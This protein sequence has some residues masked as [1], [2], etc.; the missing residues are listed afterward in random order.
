MQRRPRAPSALEL[1]LWHHAT[2][3]VRRL[4]AEEG[5][6]EEKA[7]PVAAAA[8][9][10]ATSK[11]PAS[12][13]K[14]LR[15]TKPAPRPPP[16]PGPA[17]GNVDRRTWQRLQR[18]HYPISARI[19]LHGMTQEAAHAALVGFLLR[20]QKRGARCVL[21]ITGRGLR[22]G[23]V[24]RSMTPRWL[25]APP[26]GERVLAYCFARIPHGG[27]GALYVLLRRPR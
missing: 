27:D 16:T 17:P 13:A 1:A 11:A 21:V 23:G 7:E 20:E 14:A 26:L 15:A 8:P 5:A 12:P 22:S 25:E 4:A 6:S 18:G 3:D 24:L 2:R 10:E 9:A 19:D